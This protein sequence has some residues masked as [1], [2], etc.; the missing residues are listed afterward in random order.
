[1]SDRVARNESS[2]TNP[3]V[4]S[5]ANSREQRSLA[6]LNEEPTNKATHIHNTD[7]QSVWPSQLT[8][9]RPLMAAEG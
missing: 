8:E 2:T 7:T 5:Q 3:L 9:T 1:M 6:H 4:S